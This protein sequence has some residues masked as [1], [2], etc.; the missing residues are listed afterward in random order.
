[1]KRCP[2]SHLPLRE[3]PEWRAIHNDGGYETIFRLIGSDVI[4]CEHRSDNGN[5]VLSGIDSKKFL[6]ILENLN[7]LHTPIYLLVNLENV[8]DIGYQYRTDF[9]NFAFNW[10]KNITMLVLYN[11]RDEI[12][13]RLECFSAIAPEKIHMTFANSYKD[14]LDI[15]LKLPEHSSPYTGELPEKNGSE[16]LKTKLLASITRISLLNLLDQPVQTSPAE[17]EFYDYFMAVEEFRKDMISKRKHDREQKKEI[18]QEYERR[19]NKQL[20]DLQQEIDLHKKQVQSYK[21]TVTALHSGIALRDEQ[22]LRLNAVHAEKKTITEL[23]CKQLHS[24]D[25]NDHF[26]N[27]C[28]DMGDTNPVTEHYDL[29]LTASEALFLDQLKK[30]HP[31]LTGDDVKICLLIRKNYSTKVIARLSATSTRG[32]ES[33]RYRLHKKLG[34]QKNQSIKAYLCGF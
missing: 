30:N 29:K 3:E 8:T 34:L 18:R 13:N 12:R 17:H 15:I 11:V 14:A 22:L 2:A 33:I 4:H 31:F 16:Q 25:K 24:I 5:I 21:N 23:L 9:L 28:P 32:I 10:G 7:L 19:Y 6:S 20:S 1:M 26:G 27:L